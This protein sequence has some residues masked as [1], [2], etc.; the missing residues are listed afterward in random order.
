M[1]PTQALLSFLSLLPLISALPAAVPEADALP[2]AEPTLTGLSDLQ[3]LQTRDLAIRALGDATQNDLTNGSPCKDVTIIFARGTTEDG[4]VGTSTGP[5]FFE[6]LGRLIGP[7]R[8][9]VQGVNYA[10]NVGGF[11]AGGDRAGSALMAQL[12]ARAVTQCPGTKLVLG[13]YSQGAQV[14]HNAAAQLSA[15]TANFV[16]SVVTFGDPFKNRGFG[17]IPSSKVKI[18]CNWGDNICD[19]GVLVLYPHLT[20]RNDAAAAAAFVKSK[21]GI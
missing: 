17:S 3:D 18:F 13:G 9:A 15:T 1:K 10:A 6:A 5:P 8:V 21:A 16:N 20:Y 7:S 19:G 14:V 12:A 4:N 11:L 2:E